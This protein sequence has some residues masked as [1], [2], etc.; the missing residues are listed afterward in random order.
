MEARG[1]VGSEGTL[2]DWETRG[3][4]RSGGRS[5]GMGWGVEG[6]AG[7]EERERG[8]GVGRERGVVGTAVGAMG[9][10]AMVGA[11][12]EGGWG[13]VARGWSGGRAASR[14]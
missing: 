3:R 5:V 2:A 13:R 7:K 14:S 8:E 1:E 11:G 6:M 12:E 4:C 10:A 9:R